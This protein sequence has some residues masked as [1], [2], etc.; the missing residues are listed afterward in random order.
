MG[1]SVEAVLGRTVRREIEIRK[2][3]GLQ[4]QKGQER[5]DEK[6]NRNFGKYNAKG[7]K[8]HTLPYRSKPKPT[9]DHQKKKTELSRKAGS[10]KKCCKIKQNCH[11]LGGIEVE[12]DWHARRY[13]EVCY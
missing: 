2:G 4:R 12:G 9:P 10:N 3:G 11:R 7:G 1:L 5:E 6:N 8:K 13:I